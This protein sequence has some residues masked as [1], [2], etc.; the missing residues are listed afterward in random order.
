M[1]TKEKQAEEFVNQF[2][3]DHEK[4]PTYDQISIGLGISKTA[5]YYRCRSFRTKLG[6][7]NT[8]KYKLG[9]G[10]F[11]SAIDYMKSG[12]FAKRDIVKNE[13]VVFLYKKEFMYLHQP[14]GIRFPFHP[15]NEDMIT[16]DWN[17]LPKQ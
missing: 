11:E 17:L 4:P 12:G 6:I 13:T 14:T 7:T 8:K 16:N 5:A 10:T 3:S 1:T 2:I 9:I 15:S